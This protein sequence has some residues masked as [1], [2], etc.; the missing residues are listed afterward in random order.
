MFGKTKAFK[1]TIVK[2]EVDIEIKEVTLLSEEEYKQNSH[3][4]PAVNWWWWLRSLGHFQYSA[5]YV[6]SDGSLYNDNVN[7]DGGRVRPA[8]ICNLKSSN[9]KPGDKIELANKIWTVL[10]NSI[11]L[12]DDSIGKSKFREDYGAENANVYEYS[13][14]KKIVDEWAKENLNVKHSSIF[15]DC[16]VCGGKHTMCWDGDSTFEDV[17][18]DGDGIVSML[19][20][21]NC[22]AEIELRVPSNK[23]GR[24]I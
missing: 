12:C 2:E 5:A 10:N 17:G 7:F 19:H 13:D 21:V 20:C 24:T 3:I 11:V 22:E 4:I 16:P 6:D 9:L 14:V 1:Q 23:I 15:E 18:M 8:L